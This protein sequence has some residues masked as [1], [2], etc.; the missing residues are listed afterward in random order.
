MAAEDLGHKVEC[1]MCQQVFRTDDPDRPTR[2]SSRGDDD[3]GPNWRRSSSRGSRRERDRDDDD[4][5]RRRSR[6]RDEDPY[7]S[8]DPKAW[9]WKARRDLA[10]PGAGLEVLGWL[11]IAFGLISV[12]IGILM[13]IGD[14]SSITGG[15]NAV[16]FWMNLGPG[17]SGVVLGAV[18]AMGGRQMK[19]AKNRPLSIAACVAGCVPL[20]VSCC[21][22]ILT[23]PAYI[24]GIVFG[25]MGM[26]Q[27]FNR[28]VRKAFEA[29]RP[30]GDIDA[31]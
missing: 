12:I 10:T 13:G 31:V 15:P 11:D 19:Q 26:T 9:V 30:D 14:P 22:S 8:S 21:M 20:N 24:V 28:N 18:K 2:G 27:L 1:P 7:E 29:N 23:F 17:I 16:M 5:P 3:D 4:R 25:I 6:Y